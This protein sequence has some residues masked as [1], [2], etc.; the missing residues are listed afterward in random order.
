M[1]NDKAA[2]SSFFYTNV[3]TFGSKILYRGVE[4]GNTK[5][6]KRLSFQPTLFLRSN[7]PTKFTTIHGEYVSEVNPGTIYECREFVKQYQD[8]QN[9]TIY[10]MQRYE[11]Q[12][13][14]ETFPE[15]HIDWDINLINITNID[16]EVGS[17]NGFP[18]P[19][20]AAEPITAI[21]FKN[22]Q[23]K[24]I[25]LGCGD[26]DNPRPDVHYIK[27]WSETD[28]LKRFIDEWSGDYP[29]IITGW[30]VKFFDIPYLI[31][32]IRI[33]L[34]DDMAN[35]ISPWN[36][37]SERTVVL[38][39]RKQ[40]SYEPI[41][42]AILD[43]LELYKKFAP[44]GNSQES[45]KLDAICHLELNERKM[46]YEEYGN[47]HN[48]YK[49]NYQKFI[50][51]NIKD[52]ELVG[53][54]DDK[55][56]LIELSLTLA[57][58]NKCNYDDVFTQVRMWDVIIYNHLKSKNIVIPPLTTHS[59][60]SA[61][62]GAYV[63][64][65]ILGMHK[66]VASFDLN[67]LYPHL[68]MQWNI[69]PDT[70]IPPEK[71]TDTH[72]R[73][74][75]QGVNVNKLLNKEIELS[76]LETINATLSP[77]AQFF[78]KSKQ[79]FLAELMEAM[80]NDRA[81][82]KKKSIEAKKELE[83]ET[84]PAKRFEVEKRIA[85]YNNLQ[86][87]KK[88][89]LNSAY[90]ALG[91]EYFRFFDIRLASAITTSGQLAIRWIENEMNLY[92]NKILKNT[93]DKDYVIASDTDSIYLSLAD[94]VSRTITEEKPNADTKYIIAFMDRV[95]EAK[96][97]QFIDKSYSNLAE[98]INAYAQKM[99][100]KREALADKGIWTAKKRYILNVHNNE[101]VDYA[102]PKVKVMGL[103]MVKSSTP[104]DCRDKLKKIVDIILNG[105]EEDVIAFID[106]YRKQFS[107]TSP[108]EISFPRGVNGL[109][110]YSHKTRIYDKGTPIHVRGSLLYNHL[111]KEKNLTKRYNRINEGE[112]IKYIYLKEPN[113]IQS[114][115]IAFPQSLPKEF[116]LDNYIDYETQ[117]EKA[118]VEPVRIIL[119][120]IGWKTE[121]VSS[122][123]DF[124]A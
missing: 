59:K 65:P 60:D 85:R 111:L 91:S 97:Q 86:L 67:S 79:G 90:G 123:E 72:H 23:G 63:K 99:K 8:V 122:L 58:D 76:A 61:Y 119:N 6:R 15:R 116:G 49:E 55:L 13:I 110:E 94:L 32:R 77:N 64:D 46:S 28:L 83:K 118:F 20:T 103:E 44:G 24:F 43:Y 120:A 117:Y 33:L 87:A 34:G 30:N 69:S 5:V 73:I 68:I 78:D 17:E 38:M 9:F 84:D 56:K 107:K 96:I 113:A 21:T 54:L 12:Y 89:S 52:V 41:G 100:M 3:Q 98:Y 93:E 47:L 95:C 106:D 81:V 70:F 114:D 50:E 16:I 40:T 10:G 35:R 11:Y 48:L 108:P 75:S 18:E 80:Y 25:A 57:Y 51:Y 1:T 27:C 101:G 109:S 39:G 7:Q 22:N 115:I 45:Y 62:I 112:K 102:K 124:F 53:R 88:V 71:Y 104:S 37:L 74:L 42:I 26:F 66:W 31:N 82:Y 4:N 19:A 105:T 2:S 121:K 92:M 36:K 29:D 14:A